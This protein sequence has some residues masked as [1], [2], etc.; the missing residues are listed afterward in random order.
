MVAGPDPVAGEWL[1]PARWRQLVAIDR[2]PPVVSV[3]RKR[4]AIAGRFDCHGRQRL[5]RPLFL[6]AYFVGRKV[7][8]R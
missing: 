3:L 1:P 7:G 8:N 5:L 4:P 2:S 6:R